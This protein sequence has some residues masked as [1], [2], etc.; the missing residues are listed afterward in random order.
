M[1]GRD[2]VTWLL[3]KERN[4]N[5]LRSPSASRIEPVISFSS[6]LSVVSF[7]SFVKSEKGPVKKLEKELNQTRLRKPF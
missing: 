4:V 7:V 1:L 6:M 5:C 3:P 2:P